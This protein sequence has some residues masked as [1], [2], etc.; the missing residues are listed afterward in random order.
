MRTAREK[1]VRTIP[2]SE[3]IST[4][5]GTLSGGAR[6]DDLGVENHL[7]SRQVAT[8]RVSCSVLL[9]ERQ[10]TLVHVPFGRPDTIVPEPF[11]EF[12]RRHRLLGIRK[13]RCD[14]GSGTMD[15]ESAL[16]IKIRDARLST[17]QTDQ[18]ADEAISDEAA[19]DA[20]QL[21]FPM[22]RLRVDNCRLI[23]AHCQ[24]RFNR[25]ADLAGDRLSEFRLVFVRRDRELANRR[26]NALEAGFHHGVLP[27]N[28]VSLQSLQFI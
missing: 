21:V 23:W 9:G 18:A 6:F 27:T 14:R 11:F 2:V 24:P 16:G 28:A 8:P 3:I 7:D 1:A 20:E 19:A 10:R 12:P 26:L 22:H 15:G 4:V 5:S 13:L 17:D 25:L